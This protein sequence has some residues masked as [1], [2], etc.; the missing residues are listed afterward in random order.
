MNE[1]VAVLVKIIMVLFSVFTMDISHDV[2]VDENGD[3]IDMLP[4]AETFYKATSREYVAHVW[5][6]SNMS[7]MYYECLKSEGYDAEI[8]IV[9]KKSLEAVN[10]NN[11]HAMV[12]IDFGG[13]IGKRYYD[14]PSGDYNLLTYKDKWNFHLYEDEQMIECSFEYRNNKDS[15]IC[16]G[17]KEID[18]AYNVKVIEDE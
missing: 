9:K 10:S 4:C 11:V 15:A 7:L 17:F 5:D 13:S 8:I 16:E 14:L 6:C 12:E 3:S 2:E 18:F 1:F